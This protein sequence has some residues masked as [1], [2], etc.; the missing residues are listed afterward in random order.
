MPRTFF[1]YQPYEDALPLGF[2]PDAATAATIPNDWTVWAFSDIH[3]F[4]VPFRVALNL[5]GLVDPEGHWTAGRGIAVV[6]VGD[7]IDRGPDSAGVVR[8]LRSL[9]VEMATAGSRLVL[10]R[11]NHEQMV[12][13]IIRG[14]DEWF[15][16]WIHN[17]GDACATSF[18]LEDPYVF[19][20]RFRARH[21]EKAPDLEAWLA[22]TLPYARWRDVLF[23]HAGV[24]DGE[25]LETLADGDAQLWG[26]VSF[27]ASAGV[28]FDP[29]LAKLRSAGIERV[30]VGHVAQ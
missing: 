28:E 5:A 16:S 2:P 23:V 22:G 21:L 11:G 30:V 18:G 29:T 13:D 20:A 6:G 7:Y 9:A 26:S 15:T 27:L 10:V 4:L 14:E 25:D 19:P 8:C 1:R 12:L 3:G 24:P 17:G